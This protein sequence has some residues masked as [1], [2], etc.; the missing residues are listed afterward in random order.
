MASP[1]DREHWQATL[2]PL[3]N[4][5]SPA[6]ALAAYYAFHHPADRT[7]IFVHHAPA[8][9]RADGFL[10]RA[11]TGMDLFRP[12]VTL[13][14]DTEEAAQALLREGLLP[15]RPC[16]LVA[17]ESLRGW[18]DKYLTVSEA[19]TYKISRY[20]PPP[21]APPINVLLVTSR[22][23]DGAPRAEIRSATNKAGAVAGV[24]WMSPRWAEIYVHTDPAVR[25]RGWGK[26]V[27]ATVARQL[28]TLGRLPI[29]VTSDTNEYSMRLAEAVGFVDTGH[30]E[31]VGQAVR[32]GEA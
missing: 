5:Q 6:D 12:L 22:G 26:T 17:P 19:E 28:L 31:Y 14:A 25:G 8:L 4:A 1:A 2:A 23:Q 7:E 3:L 9:N 16:Y 13:R 29:Y 32:T 21:A 27:V 30:R 24:N 15:G 18:L 20:I 11:R 10:I